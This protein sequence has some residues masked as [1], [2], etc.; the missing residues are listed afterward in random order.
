MVDRDYKVSSLKCV[1]LAIASETACR[2]GL[3][4]TKVVC[5]SCTRKLNTT[6]FLFP[7]EST[8]VRLRNCTHLIFAFAPFI[9]PAA[10]PKHTVVIICQAIPN[11]EIGFD[12]KRNWKPRNISIGFA[13]SFIEM[14]LGYEHYF[15]KLTKQNESKKKLTNQVV[16]PGS[17]ACG[18]GQPVLEIIGGIFFFFF[19]IFVCKTLNAYM[20]II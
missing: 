5:T 18:G 13:V 7:K 1:C 3:P 9:L 19:Y 17:G 11:S 12:R 2:L 8:N 10:P 16:F 15:V 20:R 14:S 4:S 6:R